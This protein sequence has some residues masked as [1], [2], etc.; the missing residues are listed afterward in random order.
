MRKKNIYRMMQ[1]RCLRSLLALA[2]TLPGL[3][4]LQ[5]QQLDTPELDTLITRNRQDL[6][7]LD[8]TLSNLP[9]DLPL[10]ASVIGSLTEAVRLDFVGRIWRLQG[11]TGDSFRQLWASRVALREGYRR[12]LGYYTD[13]AWVLLEASAPGIVRSGDPVAEHYLKLAFR[14]LEV[15]RILYRQ[16]VRYAAENP[17]LAIRSYQDGIFRIRMARRYGILALI[18]SRT[19]APEKDRFRTIT[20]DDLR[21]NT[22]ADEK[23]TRPRYKILVDRLTN[24][25]SR[26]ILTRRLESDSRGYMIKL[27]LFELHDDNYG[28]IIPTHESELQ[29]VYA[30]L[31]IGEY[32]KQE[33]LPRRNTLNRFDVPASESD[34]IQPVRDSNFE[35]LPETPRTPGSDTSTGPSRPPGEPPGPT[36]PTTPTSPAPAA[37]Q[38]KPNP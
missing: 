13:T 2:L 33:S 17:S 27:D 26:K 30:S 24:L 28:R 14:D 38:N 10:K 6:E 3:L 34:P 20:L 16:A 18:E 29:K 22:A 37:P 15:A 35:E 12:M 1:G 7:F 23:D 25:V 36:A 9:S 4:S 19:P 5:A 32:H 8:I 11:K 31:S 21:E